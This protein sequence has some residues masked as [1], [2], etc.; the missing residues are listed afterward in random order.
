LR[1]FTELS[2]YNSEEFASITNIVTTFGEEEAG[3]KTTLL[4]AV[5]GDGA[6][7]CGFF[8]AS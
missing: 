2:C 1:F 8:C 5:M 7:N 3:F 4:K 6:G